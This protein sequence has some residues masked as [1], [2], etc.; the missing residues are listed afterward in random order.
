MRTV[1]REMISVAIRVQNYSC[2]INTE[3]SALLLWMCFS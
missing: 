3:T 2:N 1:H